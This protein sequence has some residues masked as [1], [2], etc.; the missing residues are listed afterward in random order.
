MPIFKKPLLIT[1]FGLKKSFSN[2]YSKGKSRNAVS[3][4]Q[5]IIFLDNI[6]V[7]IKDTLITIKKTQ[8]KL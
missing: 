4:K 2:S 7:T 5:E 6:K 3:N 8:S 1:F